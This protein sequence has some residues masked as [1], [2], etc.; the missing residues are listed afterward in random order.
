MPNTYPSNHPP[1]VWEGDPMAPWNNHQE[2]DDPHDLMRMCLACG[3]ERPP[4]SGY[5]PTDYNEF[6]PECNKETPHKRVW[7]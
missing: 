4:R 5:V 6:C 7:R 3:F 2:E 1:G